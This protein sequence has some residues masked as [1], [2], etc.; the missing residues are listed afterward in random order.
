MTTDLL[1]IEDDAGDAVLVQALLEDD[2]HGVVAGAVIGDVCGHGPDEAALGVS[3][4]ISWRALALAEAHEDRMLP[5]LQEVLRTER[6]D[7]DL[8]ATVS[9]IT[10]SADRSTIVVR[11]AGHP[12]PV[13]FEGA[14]A[15]ELPTEQ[16][17]PIGVFDDGQWPAVSFPLPDPWTSSCT[18]TA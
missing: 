10:I 13:L 3:L 1:L 5:L 6:Q 11:S 7:P 15:T 4:R 16:G 14:R 9:Q 12:Q 8:F 2:A 18:P 17:P